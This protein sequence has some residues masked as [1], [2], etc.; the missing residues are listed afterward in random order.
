MTLFV[1]FN[2]GPKGKL[3]IVPFEGLMETEN[4]QETYLLLGR[5]TKTLHAPMSVLENAFTF[6]AQNRRHLLDFTDAEVKR[7]SE[8][9][10][11][12]KTGP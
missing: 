5:V 11:R 1:K 3:T 6:A 9:A 10:A 2:N 7:L 12:P 4:P 8:M